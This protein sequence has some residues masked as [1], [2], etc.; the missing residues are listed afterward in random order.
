MIGALRL[1]SVPNI[2]FPHVL[3]VERIDSELNKAKFLKKLPSRYPKAAIQRQA[4]APAARFEFEFLFR[5]KG[6][7]CSFPSVQKVELARGSQV[8]WHN[9]KR[10]PG[11]L[12]LKDL[13]WN[14]EAANGLGSPLQC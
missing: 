7:R 1:Q 12:L 4:K 13:V 5:L 10:G 6:H 11:H 3:D 2:H 8:R 9:L 14:V